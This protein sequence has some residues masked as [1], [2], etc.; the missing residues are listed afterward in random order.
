MIDE[1]PVSCFSF[2]VLAVRSAPRDT[3]IVHVIS[4]LDVCCEE[5]STERKFTL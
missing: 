1:V 2:S 4:N 5:R 3:E